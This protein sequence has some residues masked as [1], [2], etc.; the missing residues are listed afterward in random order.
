MI[1]GGATVAAAFVQAGLVDEVRWYLAPAVL[2]AGT[3]AIGDLGISTLADRVEL[4]VSN[5]QMCGT[6]VRIEAYVVK[7]I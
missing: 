4:K 2:G 1:E 3:P 7:E 5:V 6:D